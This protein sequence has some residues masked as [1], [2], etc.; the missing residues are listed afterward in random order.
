ML[1]FK[2]ALLHWLLWPPMRARQAVAFAAS[3]VLLY[4]TNCMNDVSSL[5]QRDWAQPCPSASQLIPIPFHAAA[6]ALRRTTAQPPPTSCPTS[7]P[8][9]LSSH[10]A[11][12]PPVICIY[13][14]Q[15]LSAAGPVGQAVSPCLPGRTASSPGSNLPACR[16]GR[17]GK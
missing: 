4:S 3:A 11:V 2:P 1:A 8:T 17:M 7:P 10:A 9:A 5:A 14:W 12:S 13:G 15:V 6:S 16:I